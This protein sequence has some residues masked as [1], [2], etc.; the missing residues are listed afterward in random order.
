M[1]ITK[2]EYQ[3]SRT[4]TGEKVK[5]KKSQV[6]IAVE[7]CQKRRRLVQKLLFSLFRGA[8]LLNGLALLVT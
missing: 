5:K 4:G 1:E 8:A 7:S 2:E 3:E 6:Q